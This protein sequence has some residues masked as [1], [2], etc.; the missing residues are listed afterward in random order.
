VDDGADRVEA[1]DVAFVVQAVDGGRTDPVRVLDRSVP[2][3]QMKPWTI[4]PLPA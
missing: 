2:P 1:D 3:D 4:V